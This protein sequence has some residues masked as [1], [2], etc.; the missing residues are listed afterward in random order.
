M[1][2]TAV[3]RK[4][5]HDS[6]RSLLLWGVVVVF[7]LFAGLLAFLYANYFFDVLGV[8]DPTA[9]TVT[10]GFVLLMTGNF[11]LLQFGVG[12][13]LA[14]VPVI[15]LLLGYKSIA[16]ER[17]SGQIKILLGLPHSRLDVVVGKFA[18]RSTVALIGIAVGFSVAA[19]IVLVLKSIEPVIFIQFVVAVALFTL[20]HVSIGVGI[21][22][23]SPSSTLSLIGVMGFVGIFQVLWGATFFVLN[24]F[25]FE[26]SGQPPDW[27]RFLRNLSPGRAYD[28]LMASVVP[29]Y[30]EYKSEIAS[31]AT[32]G[33]GTEPVGDA[34]FTQDWFGVLVLVFWAVVPL[35]IG[36]WRFET[37]DLG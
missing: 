13:V 28:G 16:G 8:S 22:A 33:A 27:F 7:V 5:F 36:Y 23:A 24:A 29:R 37:D 19:L 14:L 11:P 12:P 25:V 9:E 26:F 34:F 31:N 15:G 1:S 21:S 32:A 2:W 6:V 4:D 20:V 3:A 17:D 35:A 10:F 30:A 18:G